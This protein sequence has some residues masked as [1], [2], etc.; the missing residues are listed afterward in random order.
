MRT[1]TKLV[2]FTRE[3]P[4]L[5]HRPDD[6][7]DGSL[8]VALHGMGMSAEAF[9][10]TALA[11]APPAASVLVPQAPLP[12]EMR[13]A[14]AM[15]QGNGWYVYTGEDE[16]FLASMRRT[17][18]WLVRQIDFAVADHGLD[19]KNLSLL[20]FSQGGYLAGWMGLRH[21][22]RLRHL[23]VAAARIKHEVLADDARRAAAS[24]LRVLQV[25]GESDENVAAAA[26]K[27]SC[28][29]LAA[30]G[31]AAEFRSY[32]GGHAVLK[33]ARCRADVRQFLAD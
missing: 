29:A 6:G 27:A 12:F 16:A 31:V 24:G 30:A 19:A 11:L 5:L 14:K 4:V 1:L 32:P 26:A 17:E 21:S 25:H 7:G 22:A 20:G 23:V 2:P 8:V 18:E 28:E 13:T 15:R 9:A 10:E 3:V 33:D